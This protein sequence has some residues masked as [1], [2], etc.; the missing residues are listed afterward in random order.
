MSRSTTYTVI[1]TTT[2]GTDGIPAL[3][4]A[5]KLALRRFGLRAID[6]RE[7]TRASRRRPAPVVGVTQARR[8]NNGATGGMMRN[9]IVERIAEAKA[10]RKSHEGPNRSAQP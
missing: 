1:F 3:R 6:I 9:R 7:H 8:K 5:L 2:P 10:A 4:G